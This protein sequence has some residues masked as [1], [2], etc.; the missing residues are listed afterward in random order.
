MFNQSQSFSPFPW[1]SSVRNAPPLDR[2]GNT[3]TFFF[4]PQASDSSCSPSKLSYL[5]LNSIDL[6]SHPSPQRFLFLSFSLPFLIS[7]FLSPTTLSCQRPFILWLLFWLPPSLFSPPTVWVLSTSLF[8]LPERSLSSK[9]MNRASPNGCID[10]TAL[11]HKSS[12]EQL[13]EPFTPVSWGTFL[14]DQWSAED[15][16]LPDFPLRQ[17]FKVFLGIPLPYVRFFAGLP[18]LL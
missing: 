13:L 17:C 7:G 18:W 6:F 1:S 8:P 11:P 5:F 10:S 3:K 12:P 16:F 9:P 14:P 2:R 15:F 4:S